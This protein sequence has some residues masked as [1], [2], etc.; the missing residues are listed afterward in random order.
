MQKWFFFS[1][2]L[3]S[4]YSGLSVK[5]LYRYR[6]YTVNKH[7]SRKSSTQQIF[8]SSLSPYLFLSGSMLAMDI[9][10][11]CFTLHFSVAYSSMKYECCELFDIIMLWWNFFVYIFFYSFFSLHFDDISYKYSCRYLIHILHS[12]ASLRA[13]NALIVASC[14]SLLVFI[15][16]L[17]WS[18]WLSKN[19]S[20]EW[21]WM[22]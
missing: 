13:Y 18:H 2:S 11:V 8:S 1:R 21:L 6:R 19:P 16:Y 3:P 15:E 4:L 7:L 12:R 14:Q 20:F 9:F 5:W 22:A 17:Y 10:G